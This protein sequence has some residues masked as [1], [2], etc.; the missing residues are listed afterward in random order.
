MV[1]QFVVL[2]QW[3]NGSRVDFD[4]LVTHWNRTLFGIGAMLMTLL[5]F[6]NGSRVFDPLNVKI[7]G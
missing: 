6:P 5:G 4:P 3:V 7:G 1:I 2:L